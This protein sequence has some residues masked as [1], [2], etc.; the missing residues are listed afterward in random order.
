MKIRPGVHNRMAILLLAILLLAKGAMAYAEACSTQQHRQ[1]DFWLGDWD[2]F[3]ASGQQVG[4][5][6]IFS[7]L[8]GCALSENWTSASGN[9][10]KSYNF[11]DAA[12]NKW[13]QTW[14]DQQGGALYLDGGLQQGK[15]VLSGTRPG[16]NGQATLERITWTRLDDGRVK[17]HWQSSPDKGAT[18]AEVFV[19]YYQPRKKDNNN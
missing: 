7:V 17:Q 11:Y 19:G 8:D 4:R 1:F 16:K 14:I 10:G 5:N 6:H 15:M 18:W 13:H 12:E 2:V 3:D 9:A